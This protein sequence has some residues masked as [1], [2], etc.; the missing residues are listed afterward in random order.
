MLLLL[1][2]EEK[3]WSAD[4]IPARYFGYPEFEESELLEEVIPEEE[5]LEKVEEE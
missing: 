3:L 2:A 4:V 5:L 1:L